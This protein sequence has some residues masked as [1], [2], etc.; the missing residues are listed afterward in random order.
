MRA[1]RTGYELQKIKKHMNYNKKT[2]NVFQKSRLLLRLVYWL[3]E[4]KFISCF[5]AI[6][7]KRTI[8]QNRIIS[9]FF[10]NLIL[11]VLT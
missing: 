2:K 9:I 3:R 4:K 6:M 1:H 5:Y 10:V 7:N 8:V 11:I